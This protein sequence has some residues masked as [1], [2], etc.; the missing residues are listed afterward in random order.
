MASHLDFFAFTLIILVSILLSAGVKKS[1]MIN[2]ICTTI[3]LATIMI[4]IV[5]GA[6]KGKIGGNF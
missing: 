6:I 3:N 2:N 1:S 5:S 4:V